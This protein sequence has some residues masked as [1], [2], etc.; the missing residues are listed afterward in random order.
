MLKNIAMCPNKTD[1][2]FIT[3]SLG[4]GL[5]KKLRHITMCVVNKNGFIL[6]NKGTS[7]V[8]IMV[9]SI[10]TLIAIIIG[11]I[12]LSVKQDSIKEKE[13]TRKRLKNA[14]PK[15]LIKRQFPLKSHAT[16]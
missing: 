14:T 2:D 6:S 13:A 1:I 16:T 4:T 10:I 7:I 3:I 5:S 9:K 15:A 12:E 11:P 8:P